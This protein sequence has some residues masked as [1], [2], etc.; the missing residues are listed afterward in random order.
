MNIYNNINEAKNI[1]NAI[2]TVG[3]FDGIHIGHKAVF[4]KMRELAQ[5]HNGETVVITFYPHPRQVL[6]ID[7]SNLRFICTQEDKM[8]KFE[9]M[10]IDNVVVI[11]FTKEFSRTPSDVFIKNY[12]VE[13][14]HP[15]VVVVGYDHHFGKNRIGDFDILYDLGKRYGFSVERIKAQDVE[16]IA[17][18]S[19]KIRHALAAG[20]VAAANKLLGYQYSL[21]GTVILGNKIGRTIGFPTAN[22]DIAPQYMLLTNAGVYACKAIFDGKEYNAMANIGR[23]PTI[24]DVKEGNYMVEVNIFDFD[25]D[26]YGQTLRI[27]L[28]DRIRDE[29]KFENLDELKAQLTLDRE[30]AKAIFEVGDRK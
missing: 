23:R 11:N 16:H 1:K 4:D 26:I 7:T 5:K 25:A 20:N 29:V 21:S 15:A 22:L 14:L 27:N 6:N 18:S 13:R 2:V 3:T 8:K 19:T 12:I 10:G 24:G 17:V 30:K 9:E 28:I